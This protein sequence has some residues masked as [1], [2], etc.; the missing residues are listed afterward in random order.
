[1][2]VVFV[3]GA[4]AAVSA[5]REARS[6]RDAARQAAVHLNRGV[7]LYERKDHVHAESE[8]R[9]ALRADPGEWRA[10]YY[11][12]VIQIER[13]RFGLAIPYLERALSLNAEEPKI[14]NALGVAYFKLDRLDMARGYF[15]ASLDMDPN[16][17]EARSLMEAMAKLQ[18]RATQTVEH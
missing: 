18:H 12:G 7:A 3:V 11:V 9:R 13:R 2:T 10:P 15:Q 5:L 8:L 6:R 4:A 16:N 14:L 17:S 1:M